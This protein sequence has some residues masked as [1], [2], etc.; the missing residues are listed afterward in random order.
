MALQLDQS[1]SPP[2]G[3]AGNS[4]W[5]PL[6]KANRRRDGY[7]LTPLLFNHDHIPE[8][9]NKQHDWY[10]CDLDIHGLS[11]CF[12]GSMIV[13]KTSWALEKNQNILQKKT[14]QYCHTHILLDFSEW[15]F[16]SFKISA[17]PISWDF[18]R[19]NEIGY[20]HIICHIISDEKCGFLLI[21]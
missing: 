21:C 20:R 16:Y 4:G 6:M 8:G 19:V 13:W 10:L 9:K 3:K 14:L 15:L 17:I 2:M 7:I 12:K 18:E 11:N 5:R 1:Q